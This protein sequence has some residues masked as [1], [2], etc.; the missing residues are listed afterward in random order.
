M[1]VIPIPTDIS[2][3]NKGEMKKRN[4]EKVIKGDMNGNFEI[5]E[6][7]EHVYAKESSQNMYSVY[8]ENVWIIF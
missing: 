3:K 5:F 4:K 8:K 6:V 7:F 1:F 2:D